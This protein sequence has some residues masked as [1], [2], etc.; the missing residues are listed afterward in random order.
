MKYLIFIICFILSQHLTGQELILNPSFETYEQLRLDDCRVNKVGDIK[1]LIYGWSSESTSADIITSAKCKYFD[2]YPYAGNVCIGLVNWSQRMKFMSDEYASE[3]LI[4]SLSDSLKISKKYRFSTYLAWMSNGQDS[5]LSRYF[6]LQSEVVRSDNLSVCFYRKDYGPTDSMR[7][8]ETLSYKLEVDDWYKFGFTFTPNASY[9]RIWIGN[10]DHDKTRVSEHSANSEYLIS[11]A[12][13]DNLSLRKIDESSLKKTKSK[14]CT[15]KLI[16]HSFHS[17]SFELRDQ[18]KR[19][20][21][22]LIVNPLLLSVSEI[23]G[24][25]DALGEERSN[26][27]LSSL[28]AN[29]IFN[30]IRSLDTDIDVDIQISFLGE[31]MAFDRISPA[32]RKVVITY[33]QSCDE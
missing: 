30:Y 33:S 25:T 28:R 31:Q 8:C 4:G 3:F 6:K 15:K 12:Y 5:V 13:L 32:E 1:K 16:L 18:H 27:T 17:G 11:Y 7:H 2:K 29:A 20:I 19:L 21:D 23:L 24:Y 10:L 14:V 22:T 26:M 9:D